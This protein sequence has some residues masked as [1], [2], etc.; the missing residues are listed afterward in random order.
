MYTDSRMRQLIAIALLCLAVGCAY[1]SPIPRGFHAVW[2]QETEP[3]TD[4]APPAGFTVTPRQAYD[5]IREANMLS[6]KHVWHLYADSRYYYIHDVF[7]GSSAKL[8][9]AEGVRI[10]GQTGEIA[11]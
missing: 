10:N 6:L 2:T 5:M 1:L 11:R 8:V 7:L 9:R 3:P 4:L